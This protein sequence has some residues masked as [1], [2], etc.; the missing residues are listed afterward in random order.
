[1]RPTTS[2]LGATTDTS[3]RTAPSHRPTSVRAMM[4]GI[5]TATSLQTRST[6]TSRETASTRHFYDLWVTPQHECHELFSLQSSMGLLQSSLK[7]FIQNEFFGDNFFSQ[8]GDDDHE[9]SNGQNVLNNQSV[10]VSG[11]GGDD[12]DDDDDDDD[13]EDDFDLS[14][15]DL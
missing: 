7:K 12:G 1:M 8:R 4:A 5:P 15:D 2:R 13:D 9:D 11:G 3:S 14:D 10:V 6:A